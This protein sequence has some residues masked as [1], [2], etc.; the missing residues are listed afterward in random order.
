MH[1]VQTQRAFNLPE[2]LQPKLNFSCPARSQHTSEVEDRKSTRLN[3]SHSQ[4]SYAVFCLKNKTTAR[5]ES[6]D[7]WEDIE[8]LVPRAVRAR[9]KTFQ[10]AD[11]HSVD[12]YLASFVPAL[13][14][15]S[16]HYPLKRGT[17]RPK[18][19]SMKRRRQSE[20]FEEEWDAYAA[21]P[22]DALD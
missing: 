10:E 14:H 19:E 18:P 4:I 22:E 2:H 20:M 3:S 15:F 9:V 21:P 13:E 5:H 1:V 6:L 8:P 12:H 11:I 17:P 7:Y 16:R